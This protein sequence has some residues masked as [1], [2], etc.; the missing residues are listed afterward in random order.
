MDP[1][2][3]YVRLPR[4]DPVSELDGQLRL[5]N[6]AEAYDGHASGGLGTSLVDLVENVSTVDELG[7]AGEGDGCGGGGAAF[8]VLIS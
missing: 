4:G 2:D 6:T 3:P 8:P 5:A 1:E 7:I